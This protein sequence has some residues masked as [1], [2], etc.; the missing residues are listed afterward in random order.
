MYECLGRRQLTL[1]AT[2]TTYIRYN[3]DEFWTNDLY[4]IRKHPLTLLAETAF[5]RQATGEA[6]VKRGRWTSERTLLCAVTD[7]LIKHPDSERPVSDYTLQNCLLTRIQENDYTLE[8]SWR[9]YELDGREFLLRTCS[10][11]WFW[12]DTPGPWTAYR[13][14]DRT[15]WLHGR[16][17]FLEGQCTGTDGSGKR[18][19]PVR[20]APF[21]R[22]VTGEAA[23][24]ANEIV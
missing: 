11:E 21:E 5:K 24:E 1:E 6:L 12:R 2:L 15:W 9:K 14:H 17:W 8:R 22:G 3:D 10:D 7:C 4:A 18:A 19:F 13:H 16:R 20:S 23:E